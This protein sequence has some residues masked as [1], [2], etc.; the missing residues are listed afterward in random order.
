VSFGGWPEI[1]TTT[2]KIPRFAIGTSP[3]GFDAIK[4]SRNNCIIIGTPT[5]V[6]QYFRLITVGKLQGVR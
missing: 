6:F 1:A 4:M 3:A 2:T 5:A